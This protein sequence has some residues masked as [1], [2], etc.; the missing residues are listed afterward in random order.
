[1]SFC[2]PRAAT[3]VAF[4]NQLVFRRMLSGVSGE[5]SYESKILPPYLGDFFRD[6]TGAGSS[7]V[8][9]QKSSPKDDAYF[10]FGLL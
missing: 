4:T 10:M 2:R 7:S 1:M 8:P 6:F 5:N 9:F 3:Q